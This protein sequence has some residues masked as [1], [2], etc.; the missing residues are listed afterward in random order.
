MHGEDMVRRGKRFVDVAA[1]FGQRVADVAVEILM[2]QRCAGFERLFCIRHAGQRIVFDNDFMGGIFSLGA[3]PGDHGCHR[4]ADAV[5]R[6]AG[7]HGMSRNFHVGQHLGWREI[8]LRIKIV[9]G[10]DQLDAGHGF[11]FV[12]VDGNNLCVRVGAAL[13][14]QIKHPGQMN[15]VGITALAGDE[16]RIFD[17]F[18]RSADEACSLMFGGH[19]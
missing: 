3:R 6:A 8:Q 5:H 13:K 16:R 17:S 9:A 14:C 11:G 4:H 1:V 2:R 18:G 12:G 7:E 10:D 19:G 15:I